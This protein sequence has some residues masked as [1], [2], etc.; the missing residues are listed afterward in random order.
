MKTLPALPKTRS[1]RATAI[2]IAAIPVFGRFGFRKTSINDLA[3]AASLSKQGLYL[4]FSSKEEIFRSAFQHYLDAGLALVD[5]ALTENGRSLAERLLTAMDQWFGRH[6]VTFSA[7]SFDLIEAG[8]TLLPVEVERY[9]LAFRHRVAMALERSPEFGVAHNLSSEELAKVLYTFGLTWK[10]GWHSRAEFLDNLQLCIKACLPAYS[11]I[12]K[13]R[14]AT[15]D[16]KS[17]RARASKDAR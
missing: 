11:P 12:P 15:V 9:K 1:P 4:H 16:K 8:N 5:Q 6:L 10:E 17:A 13:A 3:A 14:I 7:G 2:L